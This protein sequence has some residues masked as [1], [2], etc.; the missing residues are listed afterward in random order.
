M[1]PTPEAI[2]EFAELCKTKCGDPLPA[3]EIGQIAEDL[4]AFLT[5]VG[6][7]LPS[8]LDETEDAPWNQDVL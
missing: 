7:P 6:R 1:T 5:V 2:R 4:L 8:D 3:C